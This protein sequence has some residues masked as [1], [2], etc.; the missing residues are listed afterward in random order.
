MIT[1]TSGRCVPPLYG[2]FSTNTSPGCIV[3][4]RASMIV[5]TL[6]PIEPRCTGMCGA[7]A[8]RLPSRVEQRA[9]EVE[10]LLDVDRVRG[11]RERHAHLLGDRHEQVVEHLEQ[12]RIGRRADRVRALRRR[13]RARARGGRAAS[14][15]ARQPGSI[16]VVALLLADHRGAGDRVARPQ[17]V[18]VED[19]RVAERA[20]GVDA[21]DAA[22]ARSGPARGANAGAHVRRGFCVVPI[23]STATASITSALPG[24]RKPYCCR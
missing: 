10:P 17:V 9:G 6:S 2:A 14:A 15:S 8:I 13:R 20:V 21:V 24:I 7:L 3:P 19:R 23:A 18:A 5:R 4:A 1:V 22:A 12:H 16:T 11:V